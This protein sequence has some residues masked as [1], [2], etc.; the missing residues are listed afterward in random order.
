MELVSIQEFEQWRCAGDEVSVSDER[1]LMSAAV[2]I[3]D[4]RSW[5]TTRRI[6]SWITIALF[7]KT[8]LNLIHGIAVNAIVIVTWFPWVLVFAIRVTK[9]QFRLRNPE[10]RG[11]QGLLQVV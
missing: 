2:W 3:A 9:N 11:D 8:R 10:I 7:I 4:I 5:I 1:L 6:L